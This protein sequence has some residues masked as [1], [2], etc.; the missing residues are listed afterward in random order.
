MNIC[1][2][3]VK[4]FRSVDD[5]FVITALPQLPRIVSKK[6]AIAKRCRGFERS[7]N[8]AKRPTLAPFVFVVLY[9]LLLPKKQKAV[10]MVGHDDTI[11]EQEARETFRQPKQFDLHN[12]PELV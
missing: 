4:V 9:S 12:L 1:A 2:N 3:V 11:L 8:R 10:E 6:K 5:M 7:D